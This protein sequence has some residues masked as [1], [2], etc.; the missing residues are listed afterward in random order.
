MDLGYIYP[1]TLFNDS[2]EGN[3]LGRNDNWWPKNSDRT[4]RGLVTVETAI[5]NSINTIS[6]QVLDK[7]TPQVSYNFLKDKL[8]VTSLV[9]SRDGHTDID[10][11]PLGLGQLTDGISLREEAAAYT[12]FPNKGIYTEGRTYSRILDASNNIV[13]DNIPE[14]NVAISEETAYWMTQILRRVVTNGT[15]SAARLKEVTGIPLAGKTGTS[16]GSSDRWFTGFTPYYVAACWTGYEYPET[17][18]GSNNPA[19]AMFSKVMSLIHNDLAPRDFYDPQN[20]KSVTICTDSGLLATEACAHDIRGNHTMT[21]MV[22]A[23]SAP[24]KLCDAHIWQDFCKIEVETLWGDG[25]KVALPGTITGAF[26]DSCPPE[27]RFTAAI[28]DP[29]KCKQYTVPT[30]PMSIPYL[31]DSMYD[32][33]VHPNQ[34]FPPAAETP[35]PDPYDPYNPNYQEVP[36]WVDQ[37][38]PQ[39]T[40]EPE[41]TEPPI[42]GGTFWE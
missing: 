24:T 16:G 12:I 32:C 35:P 4:N 25:S 28:L 10:Y 11:A 27:S 36:W 22:P 17:I 6:V 21:I 38:N 2:A 29:D 8:H 9:L 42:I 34:Y 31:V 30:P 1:W 40:P 23:G 33:Y 41:V 13:I 20:M 39:E 18:P 26:T 15:G 7:L 37:N 19:T 3:L 14:Q 5:Q